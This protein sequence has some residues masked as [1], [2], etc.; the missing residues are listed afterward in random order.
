M[1]DPP[2]SQTSKKIKSLHAELLDKSPEYKAE[3][4]LRQLDEA[5]KVRE[6][7][8]F[9][10]RGIPVSTIANI[11]KVD[12]STIYRWK[13]KAVDAYKEDFEEKQK[14]DVIS[15]YMMFCDSIQETALYE[16]ARLEGI[17]K[18]LDTKT[19]K[20]VEVKDNNRKNHQIK[21]LELALKAR[22]M[23]MDLLV[24]TG[25]MPREAS[26]VYHTLA[27]EGKLSDTTD[28]KK[29]SLRSKEQ[30]AASVLEMLEQSVSLGADTDT[31]ADLEALRAEND[32]HDDFEELVDD[33]E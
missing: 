26:K 33:D 5:S 21:F 6:V 12:E 19:G 16:A 7:W 28:E 4:D 15:E 24:T 14:A 2:T 9:Y 1:S 27:S 20:M 17:G 22:K 23:N 11:F 8:K 18:V 29:G 3:N 10:N 31:E 32:K 30:I 25:I 13:K